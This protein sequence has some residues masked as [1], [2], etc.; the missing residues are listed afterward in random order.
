MKTYREFQPTGM[1][2]KGLGLDDKQDWLVAPNGTNRD[3][4]LRTRANWEAQEK[5]LAEVD[6]EGK[7]HSVYR[8]GHWGNGWFEIILVRPETKAAEVAEE[9]DCSD[10]PVLMDDVYN[11]L[12][13]EEKQ[14]EWK[15]ARLKER[16]ELC[17]KAGIN[18]MASRRDDMPEAVSEFIQVD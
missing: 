14:A 17:N 8:F 15:R 13:Q 2:P 6:P 10:Y 11:R 3:A 12:E 4:D 9:C 1:D 7:D 5:L 18:I 16:I